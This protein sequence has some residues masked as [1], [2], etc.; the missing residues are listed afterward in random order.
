MTAA[1]K[2]ISTL[3]VDL[4]PRSAATK[5]LQV[6]PEEEWQTVSAILGNEQPDGW[7]N[8]LALPT[9]WSQNLRVLPSDR[10]LANR[11]RDHADHAELR[12]SASLDGLPETLV[13][14]DCP[15]RQGG[16]LTQNAL[17]AADGVVYAAKPSQDGVDGV[18]GARESVERFLWSRQRI[19]A[20]MDLAELGIVAGGVAETVMTRVARASLKDLHDTGLL[21]EPVIPQRTIVDQARMIGDWYGNYTKGEIVADA[22]EKVFVQIA[23]QLELSTH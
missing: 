17:A 23:Q 20:P 5:W 14:V 10:S 7:A 21:L 12:L 16:M 2:G 8:D 9:E 6:S 4:D 22:Y 13:V 3:L 1:S 15:N 19:K 18:S 11:E